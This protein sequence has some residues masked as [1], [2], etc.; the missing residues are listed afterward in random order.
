MGDRI[1]EVSQWM[2]DRRASGLQEA[3]YYCYG[4]AVAGDLVEF[5]TMT[6]NTARAIA[7][8]MLAVERQY[9]LAPKRFHL[10]DSFEGL[11]EPVAIP[12]TASPHVQLGHWAAGGCKVLG[13]AELNDLM[14]KILPKEQFELKEG[15]YSETVP[16]IPQDQVFGFIHIDC[17]LYQSTIDCLRPLFARG[18]IAPGA[19]LCFDDWMCNKASDRFGERR[20]YIE[21]CEEFRIQAESWGFYTWSGGRFLIHDYQSC[22][23]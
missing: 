10:Y 22:C 4:S 2:S 12:D 1:A 8:A 20:A 3:V 17:D 9:G 21:L 18:Q 19:V 5:G 16:L 7:E 11:P 6:G 13:K 15:W 23:S 14:L